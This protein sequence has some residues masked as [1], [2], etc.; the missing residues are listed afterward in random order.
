MKKRFEEITYSSVT[1]LFD[2]F[3]QKLNDTYPTDKYH[4][5]WLDGL[6]DGLVEVINIFLGEM[7]RDNE[8]QVTEIFNQIKEDMKSTYVNTGN[9][10]L[11]AMLT[12]LASGENNSFDI[13]E[14]KHIDKPKSSTHD[15]AYM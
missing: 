10:V 6:Y 8:E 3:K 7:Y 4:D 13:D 5:A 12:V 14:L 2:S 11:Y 1:N 9:S 15:I